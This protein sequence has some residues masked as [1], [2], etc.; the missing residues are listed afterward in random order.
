MLDSTRVGGGIVR[1]SE[2]DVG[3]EGAMITI[4]TDIHR[5][6][7]RAGGQILVSSVP[8]GLI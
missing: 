1:R 4:E 7:V 6:H 3:T 5:R 2:G 8:C